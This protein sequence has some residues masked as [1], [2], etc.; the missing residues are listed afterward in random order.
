MSQTGLE[1]ITLHSNVML[2]LSA[3]ISWIVTFSGG[4]V[5]KMQ[6]NVNGL[7]LWYQ[8]FMLFSLLAFYKPLNTD[9]QSLPLL[10]PLTFNFQDKYKE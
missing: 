9:I 4:T 7:I 5:K 3:L 1:L 10:S 8:V 6:K 2:S